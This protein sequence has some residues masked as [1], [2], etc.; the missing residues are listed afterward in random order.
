M[1][2]RLRALVSQGFTLMPSDTPEQR[3]WLTAAYE[4][5]D[6]ESHHT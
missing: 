4:E 1:I 6:H 2:K 3:A 5:H